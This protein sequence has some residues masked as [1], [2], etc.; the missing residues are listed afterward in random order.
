MIWTVEFTQDAAKDIRRLDHPVRQ[1]I[2][3]YL[4][5]RIAIDEDPRR[6]GK[7]LTGDKQGLWRYRVGDYRL[8]CSLEDEKLVVLVLRVA[9]R[10][11]VYK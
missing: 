9:H 7:I 2:L 6:F 8:I 5:E 11:H 3:R 10:R 1:Q 4:R